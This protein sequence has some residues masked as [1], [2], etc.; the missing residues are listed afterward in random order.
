M[1]IRVGG[2]DFHRESHLKNLSGII[3]NEKIKTNDDLLRI[4]RSGEFEIIQG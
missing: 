4:L 1:K 3:T 2:T